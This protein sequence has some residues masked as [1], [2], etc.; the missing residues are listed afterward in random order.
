VAVCWANGFELNNTMVAAGWATAFTRY[1]DDYVGIE[2]QTKAA[3][4]GIWS[5]VF[6]IPEIW[7]SAHEPSPR[8]SS[9]ARAPRRSAAMVPP[10]TS[11]TIKGNRNL[12]GQW[13]YHLPGMPYYGVTRAEEMFCTEAEA[14]TAGYR[15]AT[16]R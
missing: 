15:R 12:K 14:R 5:S 11:C 3:R 9:G 4:Q 10:P 1:S 7:R 13:I 8:A 16:V 6:D 2:A